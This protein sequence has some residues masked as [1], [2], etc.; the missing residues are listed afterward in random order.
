MLA[1]RFG[2]RDA[3]G[4]ASTCALARCVS[5][6]LEMKVQGCGKQIAA[7]QAL[8]HTHTHTHG[9]SV[10]LTPV[11]GQTFSRRTTSALMLRLP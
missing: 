1:N 10:S 3:I 4:G 11:S 2:A 5:A 9:L 8:A 7:L 6:Q